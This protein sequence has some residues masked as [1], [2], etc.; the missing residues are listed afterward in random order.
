M[1]PQGRK[2]GGLDGTRPGSGLGLLASSLISQEGPLAAEGHKDA[3]AG[4]G[5]SRKLFS[6]SL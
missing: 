5:F 2:D 6:P 1:G 4:V 3:R